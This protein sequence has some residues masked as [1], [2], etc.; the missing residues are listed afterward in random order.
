LHIHYLEQY[1]KPD[2]FVQEE[3]PVTYC[4]VRRYREKI[5]WICLMLIMLIS[6]SK[7]YK[8]MKLEKHL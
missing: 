8:V 5:E 3:Y 7:M 4:P 1:K 6:D 2:V